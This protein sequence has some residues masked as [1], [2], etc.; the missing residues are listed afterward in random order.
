M[1]FPQLSV[2]KVHFKHKAENVSF[3]YQKWPKNLKT[4]ITGASNL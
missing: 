1:N 3:L 4:A 2:K